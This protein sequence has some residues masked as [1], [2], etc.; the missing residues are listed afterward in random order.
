VLAI[1]EYVQTH[2]LRPGD[3]LPTH[4]ELVEELGVGP[5][6]LREGLSVLE[7]QGF[8]VT[9]GRA[10]TLVSEPPLGALDDPIGWHL[11]H[12]G[13]SREDLVEARSAMES[14]AA[15]QAAKKRSARELL[16]MLDTIEQMEELAKGGESDEEVDERFHLTILQATHNPVMLMFG[17]LISAQFQRKTSDRL[18][19][20]MERQKESINEHR[21]IYAAIEK[22]DSDRAS[23]LMAKHI[24]GQ[25]NHIRKG[26]D[27]GRR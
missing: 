22:R 11:Q 8:L 17:R 18:T 6:R 20:S 21:G 23:K 5:R 1:R 15:A 4:A 9:R 16:G 25:L 19:S 14:A 24:L 27:H 7:Q 10:G 26:S 2:R 3:R 12:M 13:C